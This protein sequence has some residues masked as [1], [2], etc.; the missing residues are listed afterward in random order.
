MKVEVE[1]PGCVGLDLNLILKLPAQ[2]ARCRPFRAWVFINVF[3]GF[4]AAL[5]THG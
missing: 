1:D 2:P 3:R 4:L 5:V